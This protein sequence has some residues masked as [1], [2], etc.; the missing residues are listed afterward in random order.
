MS[1]YKTPITVSESFQRLELLSDPLHYRGLPKSASK[2]G[3]YTGFL[4]D[5]RDRQ[6]SIGICF[7]MKTLRRGVCG[8]AHTTSV[9]ECQSGFD[10]VRVPTAEVMSIG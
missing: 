2:S 5:P 6:V 1:F 8:T 7:A 10:M 9:L 4:E 3:V